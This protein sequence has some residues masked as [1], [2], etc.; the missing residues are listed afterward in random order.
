MSGRKQKLRLVHFCLGDTIGKKL[1][2]G[3]LLAFS[4]DGL[5]VAIAAAACTFCERNDSSRFR[6]ID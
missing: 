5:R 2:H 6:M 3:N 1:E 4:T